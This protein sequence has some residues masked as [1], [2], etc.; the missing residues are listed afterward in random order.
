[1]KLH[2]LV[3]TQKSQQRAVKSESLKFESKKKQFNLE[4]FSK[5]VD[6][7]DE[8]EQTLENIRLKMNESGY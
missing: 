7:A 4:T 5:V 2:D 3:E 6:R 8:Q 1:M